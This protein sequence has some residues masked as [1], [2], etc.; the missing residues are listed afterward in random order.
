MP[1][2]PLIAAAH[3]KDKLL[4]KVGKLVEDDSFDNTA[5]GLRKPGGKGRALKRSL[6][7]FLSL[8]G[9]LLTSPEQV[10]LSTTSLSNL[11]RTWKPGAFV[12]RRHSLLIVNKEGEE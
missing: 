9:E 5:D 3:P 11:K 1:E 6:P 12:T 7:V 2:S 8:Q 4:S 10:S